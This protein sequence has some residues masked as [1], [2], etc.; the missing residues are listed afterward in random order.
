MPVQEWSVATNKAITRL[1]L[2]DVATGA[3][4]RLTSGDG[5]DAAPAWSHDG[6]RIAVEVAAAFYD[7]IAQRQL[8]EVARQSLAR[9]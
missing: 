3:T 6:T 1:W 8:L 2:V 4:R 7:V 9:T 5:S